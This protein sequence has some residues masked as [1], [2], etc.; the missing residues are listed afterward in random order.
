MR[1]AATLPYLWR[2]EGARLEASAA[3]HA[4]VAQL[5][6]TCS[7]WRLRCS[8][9]EREAF[10]EEAIATV[11]ADARYSALGSAGV[12][13]VAALALRSLTL[14]VGG[15]L[16]SAVL[17]LPLTLFAYRALVG[18]DHLGAL[19]AISLFV[20][21]ALAADDVCVVAAHWARTAT[22]SVGPTGCAALAEG[23]R[24]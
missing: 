23:P 24:L 6:A 10:T 21:A 7:K 3:L 4:V 22:T 17:A 19:H 9:F 15:V 1:L 13:L 11:K 20:A 8:W 16:G 18:F 2:D 5:E 12:L 14:A